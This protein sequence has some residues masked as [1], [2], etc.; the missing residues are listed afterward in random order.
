MTPRVTKWLMLVAAAAL[1]LY[2]VVVL[3]MGARQSTFSRV[4]LGWA[5]DWFMVPL[6]FGVVVGHLFMPRRRISERVFRLVMLWVILLL[7]AGADAFLESLKPSPGVA[8]LAGCGLGAWLW[9]QRM[10]RKRIVVF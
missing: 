1:V 10:P 5:M 9:P 2:D 3:I 8:L 4:L 6:V 7:A